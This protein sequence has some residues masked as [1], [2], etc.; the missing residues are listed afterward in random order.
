M[1]GDGE[2]AVGIDRRLSVL[3][4][5]DNDGRTKKVTILELFSHLTDRGIHELDFARRAGSGITRRVRVAA[6]DSVFNQLL[7]HAD[8]LEVYTK[9]FRDGSIA[10]AEVR[11]AVDF[12]Q[13]RIDL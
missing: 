13:D 3:G 6:L 5:D 10:G 8:G 1:A 2:E 7:P 9:D 12:I 11:F 4:G